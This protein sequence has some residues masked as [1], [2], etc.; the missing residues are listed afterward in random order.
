MV[1]TLGSPP[2]TASALE[3][4]LNSLKTHFERFGLQPLARGFADMY[5]SLTINDDVSWKRVWVGLGLRWAG[6]RYRTRG[7]GR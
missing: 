4:F 6:R 1:E 2:Y 7:K 5:H 3:I